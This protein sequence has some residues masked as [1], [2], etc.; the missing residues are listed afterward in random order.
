M[1]GL[2][3]LRVRIRDRECNRNLVHQRDIGHIV[4]DARALRG[5]QL[6]FPQQSTQRGVL[7]R[8]SLDNVS[9]PQFATPGTHHLRLAP[10]D[11]GYFDP[12][13]AHLLYSVTVADV[14]YLQS[15]AARP[16]VEAAVGHDAVDIQHQEPNGCDAR[17][18]HRFA[19][20]IKR[21]PRGTGRG[22]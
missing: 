8:L 1:S 3:R 10:R 19:P 4:T 2:L 15:F 9:D 14:E 16:E 22:C 20:L 18:L 5:R 13:F 21:R 12:G 11:H 7:I 17:T 6:Q